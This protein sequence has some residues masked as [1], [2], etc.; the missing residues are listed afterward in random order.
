MNAV[1]NERGRINRW[2]RKEDKGTSV[3]QTR[4]SGK[5]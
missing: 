1:K 2:S 5:N 3:I 4:G